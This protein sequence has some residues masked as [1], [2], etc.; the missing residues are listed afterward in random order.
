MIRSPAAKA[1]L[2]E[3]EH[4]TLAAVTVQDSAVAAPFLTNVNVIGAPG[5][6]DGDT[7][8]ESAVHATGIT[9]STRLSVRELVP[10]T[11]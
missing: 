9:F 8:K 10:L 2:F 5:A 3:D 1:T 11:A 7:T 6:L 4:A